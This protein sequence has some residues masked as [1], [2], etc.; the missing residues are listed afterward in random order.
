MAWT[1]ASYGSSLDAV[2][3][4]H[5][6]EEVRRE[7]QRGQDGNGKGGGRGSLAPT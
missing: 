4:E 5:M 3:D 6:M 1:M 2:S 7:G